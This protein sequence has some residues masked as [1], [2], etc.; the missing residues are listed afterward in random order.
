M[1][2]GIKNTGATYQSL[3]NEIFKDLIKKSMEV[4]VDDML[5]KFK[6]TRDQHLN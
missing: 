2:F 5:D 6:T 1:P 3:V 4:Y